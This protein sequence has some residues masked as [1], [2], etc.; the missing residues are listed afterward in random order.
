MRRIVRLARNPHR[1]RSSQKFSEEELVLLK[2][3]CEI[4]LTEE[5]AETPVY[6]NDPCTIC[7]EPYD[8]EK[9][10]IKFNKCSHF[11]HSVC[12]ENWLKLKS[13]CPL[14]KENKKNEIEVEVVEDEDNR[15]RRRV[16]VRPAALLRNI[17]RNLR[18]VARLERVRVENEVERLDHTLEGDPL[19]ELI[20][21]PRIDD[22]DEEEVGLGGNEN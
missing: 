11:F 6:K 2:Q 22:G 9:K 15:E 10:I 8:S 1:D 12:I 18:S 19:M 14:C 13:S 3:R 7:L 5:E 21:E 16:D 20:E 4:Q 17:R